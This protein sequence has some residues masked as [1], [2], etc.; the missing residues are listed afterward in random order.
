MISRIAVA[1]TS[2]SLGKIPDLISINSQDDPESRELFEATNALITS[3]SEARVFVA[4]LGRGDLSIEPPVH[5]YLI[6]DYKY[7]HANLKHLVWQTQQ[8]AAGDLSHS[9]DFLGS[10]AE[11]FNSMV[12][13]LR[14]KKELEVELV[15]AKDE[16]ERR[17]LERTR[18]LE[19]INFELQQ[20]VVKREKAENEL[21]QAYKELKETQEQLIQT[22][23]M[24][25][26][27][28]LAGGVAHELNN[29]LTGVMNNVQLIKMEAEAKKDFSPNDFMELLGVV[30]ASALRCK[31][32][33]QSLLD[34]SHASKGKTS[35]ISLNEIAD[36]TIEL[37]SLE[38]KLQ[39]VSFQKEL[40]PDLPLIQGDFQLLQQVVFGLINNAHWAVRK[41][42]KDG[43]VITVKTWHDPKKR[44]GFLSVSDTGIGISEENMK[45]LFT[46][47]FTTKD[48]G[49]GTGIG[50]ALFYN[51]VKNMNGSIKIESQVG[52]GTTFT[53]NL[54]C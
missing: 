30:E 11:A 27:G 48:V 10:F 2:L 25:A 1:L 22:S 35:P 24:S 21:Q 18:E 45:K 54:P 15:K 28:Q 5:N 46:P 53:I 31:S 42:S 6:A 49:E 9:V 7:L 12:K 38:L 44:M 39:G 4:A 13:S 40:Q 33:T 36:K 29:P 23:K 14:R 41:K 52:I 17:V 51:I 47:F 8:V 26:L 16:L 37:I 43:G 50:L 3:F 32:I 19:D 34:F 20:Q